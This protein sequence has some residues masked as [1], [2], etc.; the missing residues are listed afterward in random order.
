[1]SDSATN[2]FPDQVQFADPVACYTP[3]NPV[4]R[5]DRVKEYIHS[6]QYQHDVVSTLQLAWVLRQMPDEMKR[7]PYLGVPLSHVE[8]VVE[9]YELLSD[10]PCQVVLGFGLNEDVLQT[11]DDAPEIADTVN[12]ADFSELI[13][14]TQASADRL[15]TSMDVFAFQFSDSRHLET[16]QTIVY[17]DNPENYDYFLSFE[18]QYAFDG[19]TGGKTFQELGPV[20]FTDTVAGILHLKAKLRIDSYRNDGAEAAYNERFVTPL[21]SSFGAATDRYNQWTDVEVE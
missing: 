16:N 14:T 7:F 3:S 21:V 17:A 12:I 11:E 15:F 10:M 4:S 18:D 2:G 8:Q 5:G 1:M 9:E 6:L 13:S 20:E 19:I